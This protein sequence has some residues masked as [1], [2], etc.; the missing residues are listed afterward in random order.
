MDVNIFRISYRTFII[1]LN[2]N[3]ASNVTNEK[4]FWNISK[5]YIYL[6]CGTHIHHGSLMLQR[7][8]EVRVTTQHWLNMI[9]YSTSFLA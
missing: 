9:L 6:T 5:V 4:G 3:I 1:K 7:D 2:I 8:N